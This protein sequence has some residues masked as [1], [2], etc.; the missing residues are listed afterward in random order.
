MSWDIVLHHGSQLGG[1]PTT[2]KRRH[3]A[4]QQVFGDNYIDLGLS[5]TGIVSHPRTSTCQAQAREGTD[6]PGRIVGFGDDLAPSGRIREASHH[7]D[8]CPPRR[9]HDRGRH[10]GAPAAQAAKEAVRTPRGCRQAGDDI[11]TLGQPGPGQLYQPLER[12]TRPGM[13]P[14]AASLTWTSADLL[15]LTQALGLVRVTSR[16][17]QM[18][19]QAALRSPGGNPPLSSSSPS[20]SNGDD[21]V[22]ASSAVSG[23]PRFAAR[24]R[25]ITYR[26]HPA[27][28]RDSALFRCLRVAGIPMV[29]PGL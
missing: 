16:F 4:Y 19:L 27:A 5:D 18:A 10:E 8:E 1:S 3:R 29:S 21:T 28:D 25:S 17:V 13:A 24:A 9:P 14:P 7:A 11:G 15:H 6:S 26:H 20:R 22:R 2:R 12:R 23:K